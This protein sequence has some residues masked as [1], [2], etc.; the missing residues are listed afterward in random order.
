M[1]HLGFQNKLSTPANSK[2]LVLTFRY[3]VRVFE[4]FGVF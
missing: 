3:L 4:H 1:V 2:V